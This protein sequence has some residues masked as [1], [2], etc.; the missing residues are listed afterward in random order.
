ITKGSLGSSKADSQQNE[1]SRRTDPKEIKK[2]PESPR[3]TNAAISESRQTAITNA[4]EKVSPAIVS[5]TVTKVVKGQR[6]G[7]SDFYN[8]LFSIPLKREVNSMGSGFIISKGVLV[9]VNQ[10]EAG[11]IAK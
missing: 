10:D 9:V 2:P 5:I 6:R 1:K 3:H 11:E 8:R 4:V 7:F